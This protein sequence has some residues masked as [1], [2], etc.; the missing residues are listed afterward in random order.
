MLKIASTLG[1]SFS[2]REER[3][4]EH[5]LVASVLVA[6]SSRME[7]LEVRLLVQ[8]G[9]AMRKSHVVL[10]QEERRDG[11]QRLWLSASG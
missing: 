3:T 2:L 11:R 5:I 4:P 1:D 10:T 6:F 7:L 9:F 8:E